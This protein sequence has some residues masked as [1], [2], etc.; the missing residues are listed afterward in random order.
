M[1]RFERALLFL[2]GLLA[3]SGCAVVPQNPNY[4]GPTERPTSV[5]EYYAKQPYSAYSEFTLG[6]GDN[7][8]VKRIVIQTAG[9]EV[10][11]DFFEHDKKNDD[12]IFV[13]PLLGGKNLIPNY[14]ATYFAKQGYDTAI[15]HRNEDFKNPEYFDTL[16]ETLRSSVIRDRVAIDFFEKEYGKKDFGSFGI[17]R[18]AINVAVT[19]SVDKRLKYNVLALG[20]SDIT[21]I[22]KKAKV[23]RFKQ[24]RKKI[25]EAKGITKDEFFTRLGGSIKTDPKYLAQYLD[26]RNT[27]MFLSMFDSTVPIKNGL[28]LREVIGRPRTVYLAADHFISAGY[29]GMGQLLSVGPQFSL[30]PFDYIESESLDFYE[31]KFKKRKWRMES[32][33][34][35]I[36]QVPFNLVQRIVSAFL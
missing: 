7:F 18:G 31:S 35:R 3:L 32:V 13:F 29:T 36:F 28:E 12:L 9:G 1:F 23:K 24:Y 34:L 22:F 11:T 20:G 27:L 10:V 21:D 5:D 17:S 4:S 8:S 33:P 15:V 6:R 26:S 2:A 25:M 16:E 14:F 30:F 19:A